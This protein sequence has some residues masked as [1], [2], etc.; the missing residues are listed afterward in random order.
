MGENERIMYQHI[1]LKTESLYSGL[2][3]VEDVRI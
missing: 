2:V 3:A 1:Y